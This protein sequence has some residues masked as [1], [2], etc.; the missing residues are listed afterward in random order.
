MTCLNKYFLLIGFFYLSLGNS[1]AQH[2]LMLQK[3]ANE[4]SRIRYEAGDE[5]IYLQ[6]GNDYYIKDVIREIDKNFIALNENVLSLNQIEA[7]DIRNK[8]ERNQTLDNLTFLPIA[9]GSLLLFAGGIN[10]L[11]MDGEFNY[12]NGVLITAAAMI[13]SGLILKTLRYKKFKVG[14]R[15]KL[16]VISSNDPNT[17]K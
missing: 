17:G 11:A 16:Q 1:E 15:R 14:G 10:S 6:K 13:G 7:I 4:K 12:S 3:G 5:F 2:Y 8:D 9:G